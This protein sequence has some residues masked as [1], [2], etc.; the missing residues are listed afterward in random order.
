MKRGI[1]EITINI[2]NI[3]TLTCTCITETL[4]SLYRG[5]SKLTG[6]SENRQLYR[7]KTVHQRQYNTSCTVTG[8]QQNHEHNTGNVGVEEGGGVLAES[9]GATRPRGSGMALTGIHFPRKVKLSVIEQNNKLYTILIHKCVHK[10]S[11][12]QSVRQYNLKIMQ[13][14][15]ADK[16]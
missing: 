14:N 3:K 6:N 16:L 9:P 2:N 11:I 4:K 8:I 15:I 13:W 5:N 1:P 10:Q 12:L 7:K